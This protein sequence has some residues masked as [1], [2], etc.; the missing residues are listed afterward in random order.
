MRRRA[1][2]AGAPP[3][4]FQLFRRVLLG[5]RA[6]DR[7]SPQERNPSR[8][9]R[10]SPAVTLSAAGSETFGTASLLLLYMHI[11]REEGKH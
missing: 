5:F 8:I 11:D 2:I 7:S 9:S 4:N 6:P 10:F 1:S 3:R